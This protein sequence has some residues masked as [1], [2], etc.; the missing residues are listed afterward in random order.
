LAAVA[1]L[2]K[3][4][5]ALRLAL[6]Q[7]AEALDAA[8]FSEIAPYV[9]AANLFTHWIRGAQ[10]AATGGD[11]ELFTKALRDYATGVLSGDKPA[12]LAPTLHEQRT[13]LK[14]GG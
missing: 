8:S 5:P 14:K 2:E 13:G 10:A 11:L 1:A 9:P 4:A 7:T 12:T 6:A 3:A